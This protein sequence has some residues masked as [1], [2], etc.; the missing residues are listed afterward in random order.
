MAI[1]ALNYNT[2]RAVIELYQQIA[3]IQAST[4]ARLFFLAVDNAS[5]PEE[6][7]KLVAFFTGRTDS[8][9][10]LN[11]ANDGYASGNNLG[12]QR[13]AALGHDYCLIANCDIAFVSENIFDRLIEAARILPKCGLIGPRVVLPNGRPQG[14]LPVMGILNAVFPIPIAEVRTVAPVYATSAAAFSAQ[15][16]S[17]NE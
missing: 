6:V 7:A 5:H 17:S 1:V 15:H 8:E 13:A 11:A 3:K 12:L 14:P 10:L 4:R 16:Q 9:L 2:S